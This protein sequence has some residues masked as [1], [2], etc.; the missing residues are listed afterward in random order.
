[1]VAPLPPGRS[2]DV[3]TDFLDFLLN[4]LNPMGQAIGPFVALAVLDVA[5]ERLEPAKVCQGD[6][7]TGDRCDEY[8][9]YLGF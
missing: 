2:A 7:Q 5:H 6:V 1:M 4:A 9:G 8:S 3:V